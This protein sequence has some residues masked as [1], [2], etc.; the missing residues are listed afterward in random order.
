MDMVRKFL[1]MGYIRS[2]RYA[3]HRT[4]RKYSTVDK[5]I[6]VKFPLTPAH[7]TEANQKHHVK[8][9]TN[10]VLPLNPDPVKAESA[11]IFYKFYTKVKND[12][13]YVKLKKNIKTDRG[14]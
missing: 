6:S 3:N 4:G 7:K 5:K 10:Q 11:S 14:N 13:V 8:S 1:Q 9:R 2:R 12:A